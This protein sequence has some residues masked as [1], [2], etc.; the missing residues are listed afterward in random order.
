M[1]LSRD[2]LYPAISITSWFDYFS[3]HDI[4]IVLLMYHISAV[5]S[6]LSRSF[7]SFEHSHPCRRMDHM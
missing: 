3:V 2:L 4:L 7:V 1:I 6:H 5:S